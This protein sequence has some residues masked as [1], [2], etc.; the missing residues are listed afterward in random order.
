MYLHCS[1]FLTYLDSIDSNNLRTL[2]IFDTGN[3][4][5]KLRVLK[6]MA[7]WYF[8]TLLEIDVTPKD[9]LYLQI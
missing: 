7:F 1:V 3:I 4:F 6:R 2:V 8:D 5:I 9:L